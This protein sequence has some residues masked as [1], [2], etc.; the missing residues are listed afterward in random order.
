M[1]AEPQPAPYRPDPRT[2]IAAMTSEDIVSLGSAG[3][4]GLSSAQIGALSTDNIV[5]LGSAQAAVLSSAQLAGLKTDQMAALESA[6][7][8]ALSTAALRSLSTA[9]LAAPRLRPDRGLELGPGRRFDH[10]ADRR[11]GQ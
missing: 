3:I 6:D 2:Q 9:Q 7:L 1:R 5:A 4:R 10:R 11:S 8:N